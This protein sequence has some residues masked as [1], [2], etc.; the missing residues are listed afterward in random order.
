M[1]KLALPKPGPTVG[2]I[3]GPAHIIARVKH[4]L[5]DQ[6]RSRPIRSP[7]SIPSESR[8]QRT[9]GQLPGR[10][11]PT[12]ACSSYLLSSPS[13]ILLDQVFLRFLA[14]LSRRIRL[15][16]L[17][18]SVAIELQKSWMQFLDQNLRFFYLMTMSLFFKPYRCLFYGDYCRFLDEFFPNKSFVSLTSLVIVMI[19]YSLK[20]GSCISIIYNRVWEKA[21]KQFFVERLSS[22]GLKVKYVYHKSE[23]GDFGNASKRPKYPLLL[24]NCFMTHT[25]LKLKK[26]SLRG[27]I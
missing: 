9:A 14:W 1:N 17:G 21:D 16:N 6:S 24:N 8:D 12:I 27:F 5:F 20:V 26:N 22:W 13:R 18:F 3:L 25:Y 7:I 2:T 19:R 4:V 10:L 15:C 23:F 11:R